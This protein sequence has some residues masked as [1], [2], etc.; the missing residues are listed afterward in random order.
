[1]SSAAETKLGALYINAKKTVE[2]GII[3]EEMGHPQPPTPLQTDNSTGDAIMNSH[4]QPKRTK[5]MDLHFH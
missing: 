4:M 5:A 3:L 1:M 2:E